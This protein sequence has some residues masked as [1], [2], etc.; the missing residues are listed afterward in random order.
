MVAYSSVAHLG[1]CVLGLFALNRAGIAGS[2]MQMI[3]HGLSTGGLFLLVGM[4]YERY[5]TRMM[6]DYG[7]LAARLKLLALAMVF[8]CLSSVGIPFLNGFVGEML[9]LGGVMDLNVSRGFRIAF[10]VAGAA[11]IVLGAWYLFTMLKNVFFGP[12]KEPHADPAHG[13]VGDLNLRELATLVPLVALCV[14]I[15]VYPQPMLDTIR[16]DVNV[17]SKICDDARV[18]SEKR[19]NDEN[20][21]QR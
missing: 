14:L 10:G 7:G 12:L 8:V 6:P 9:V 13:P 4:L 21:T 18:R 19:A 3:N 1:F 5:H 16:R 17:V 15:G 2:V 11:G 20:V